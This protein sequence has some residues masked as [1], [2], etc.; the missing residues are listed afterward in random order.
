MEKNLTRKTL[1]FSKGITNVPSD[2]LSE[3]TELLE[4]DGFIYKNGEMHPIQDPKLITNIPYALKYVHK[5]ADFKNLVAYD[6]KKEKIYCYLYGENGIGETSEIQSFSIGELLDVNSIGNTLVCA[7]SSG[8]HY[9][10]LKGGR[11]KDLG[12]E[13][14]TP[15]VNF[16]LNP[17]YIIT[18]KSESV[19][20][21]A[22]MLEVERYHAEYDESTR[23]FKAEAT[24]DMDLLE[25]ISGRYSNFWKLYLK[26]DE[27]KKQTFKDAITGHVSKQINYCKKKGYFVHPFFVRYALK[28][29]DGTYARISA[30]IMCYPCTTKNNRFVPVKSN[31]TT[32]SLSAESC[33]FIMYPIYCQLYYYV[34]ISGITDWTDIVKELVIFASDDVM[35]YR[36]EDGW[37]ITMPSESNNTAFWDAPYNGYVLAGQAKYHW[38][39]AKGGDEA[40]CVLTPTYKSEDEII[41]ELKSK[42]QFY[43]LFSIKVT[44]ASKFGGVYKADIV[45]N[46]V[47]NLT[48]QEQLGKDDYYGWTSLYVKKLYSYNKRLDVFDLERKP[49]KG[50]NCFWNK[51]LSEDTPIKCNFTFYVHISTSSM[52]AWVK[53]GS[54]YCGSDAFADGW[55]FYPDPNATEV[56]VWDNNN[57]KGMLLQLES[58]PLLNGSYC[59]NKLPLKTTLV[60]DD[61]ITIPTV[62]S[63]AKE[64]L[65]SQI[66]TS[67]VNNPFVFEA[68]GDNTVGTGKIVGIVANTEAVSQG[69]FGQYPL[70][71]FTD[72]GVYGMSI[73]SE[74]L[75]SSVYPI[76]RDVCLENS[77]LIPT[78]KL[79]YFSSKKGLMA[80]SG[81]S[82][83]C[84]SELLRG[85]VPRNFATF[86]EGRFLDFMKNCQI[87]YDYKD[88]ILRIFSE[89]KGYQYIYNMNDKTF[90]MVNSGMKVQSI[91]NDYPD[92][93]IQDV[94][95]NVYSLTEKPDISDDEKVYSGSFVTRPLKLGGSITLKSLRSVKHLIDTD[96]GT[97]GLEIW[98]SNDCK[99]WCQLHSMAGKPWKYFTFCYTLQGFKAVDSFAGSIV[100]I[101]SRREDKLR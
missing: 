52:D 12:T 40:L 66:Y 60:T 3:D 45:E 20:N 78:D 39:T 95:G 31:G 65:N 48:T 23:E 91:L 81:G 101:Q 80:A 68:S 22:D 30:P 28:L 9:L 37:N 98:G 43:K 96:D 69:Q 100:E 51:G 94:D 61:S 49:F 93:L 89:G 74:G 47:N 71:V 27:E 53:S 32:Y 2:L 26:D 4:C 29:Y 62:D 18:N 44:D 15:D 67:V 99:H 11:Y 57:N 64:V 16:Y 90:S 34:N 50:F 7:T 55:F 63:D 58:H 38:S 77:P 41:K 70:M 46:V 14:P 1:S 88:S 59:F 19:C 84:M 42:S 33:T 25:T 87:A 8:L 17:D 85:R 79:V 75:Y 10:L 35:P 86:G 6:K 13:L 76:S 21:L 54:K 82:T 73:N 97:I 5:G 92:N 72:E 83:A 36:L 56:I 24:G